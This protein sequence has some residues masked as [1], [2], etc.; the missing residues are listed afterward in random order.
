VKQVFCFVGAR[1]SVCVHAE[2]NM[3]NCSSETDV[4]GVSVLQYTGRPTIEVVKIRLHFSPLSYE[5]E[6]QVGRPQVAVQRYLPFFSCY[7]F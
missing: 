4:I 3:K 2:K 6:W 1:V 7:F 5:N